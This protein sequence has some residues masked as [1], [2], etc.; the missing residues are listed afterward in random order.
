MW[1]GLLADLVVAFHFVYVGFVVVGQLLICIGVFLRWRWVR[2]L[3]FRLAHL[4]A[5]GVVA[6]EG[7]F[8][9]V[10]PLTTWEA[11]LRRLAGQEVA[12][13]TFIGRW[14]HN[15]IFYNAD[16]RIL[17][18]CYIGFAVLVMITFLIAP[19]FWRRPRPRSALSG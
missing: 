9:V 17:D 6:L 7:V 11:E 16:Q 14:L 8:G 10:C 1:Y 12:E 18:L 5:I 4:L 15:L 2:N 19:P 3:W 13:G